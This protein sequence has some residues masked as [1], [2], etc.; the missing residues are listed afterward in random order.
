MPTNPRAFI[1]PAGGDPDG[2]RNG[3]REIS[4]ALKR[5]LYDEFQIGHTTLRVDQ[6]HTPLPT[7]ET[8]EHRRRAIRSDTAC[9]PRAR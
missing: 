6:E 4:H 3:C 5:L 9:P 7:I 1:R 2:E 8:D